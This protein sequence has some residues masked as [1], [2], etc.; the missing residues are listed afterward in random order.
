[1][2]LHKGDLLKLEYN[3]ED[4]LMRIVRLNPSANRL[5]LVQHNEAGDLAK[6]HADADDPFRWDLANIGKLK[7]RRARAVS[8]NEIGVVRDPGQPK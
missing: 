1:M 2:R 6:R 5:Y 8:V 4:S 7:D 3:G